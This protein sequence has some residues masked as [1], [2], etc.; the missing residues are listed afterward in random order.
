MMS[1]IVSSV[2]AASGIFDVGAA[3]LRVACFATF[4][5]VGFRIVWLT[6]F[7]AAALRLLL[8]LRLSVVFFRADTRRLC[9]AMTICSRQP[10]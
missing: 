4:L 6:V 5:A 8:L 3:F 2:M 1:T 7:L 10:L 9:F